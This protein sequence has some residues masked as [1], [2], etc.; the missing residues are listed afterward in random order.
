M[1]TTSRRD[2]LKIAT[3]DAAGA[4]FAP[5]ASRAAGKTVTILHESS[6]IPPFDEFIKKTL[7]QE[8]EKQ[9]GIKIVYE[10]AAFGS[11]PTRI[12]TIAETGSGAD[13]TMNGLLQVIQFGDKYLDVTGLYKEIGD[14]NGSS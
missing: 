9:T 8:Y 10:I 4:A 1:T 11:L 12:A 3:A 6:F 13:I 7:P 5:Q 2:F 14:K